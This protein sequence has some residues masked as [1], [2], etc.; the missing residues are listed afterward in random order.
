MKGGRFSPSPWEEWFFAS[1]FLL[2]VSVFC[3]CGGRNSPS[4]VAIHGETG[5][6]SSYIYGFCDSKYRS[7]MSKDDCFKFVSEALA[8]AMNRDGSSGGMIRMASIDKDGV[9]RRN[10]LGNNLP[11]FHVRGA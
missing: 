7:G 10:I 9:E 1:L 2:E 5:S 6:G 3:S 8:L 4:Y 11:T